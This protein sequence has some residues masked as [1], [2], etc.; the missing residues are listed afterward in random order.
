ME[1]STIVR[2]L[3]TVRER[4]DGFQKLIVNR[5]CAPEPV[6][7]EYALSNSKIFGVDSVFLFSRQ[8]QHAWFFLLPKLRSR[9]RRDNARIP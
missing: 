7:G 1:S 6:Q 9:F 3:V 2:V 4:K 5:L 8:Q